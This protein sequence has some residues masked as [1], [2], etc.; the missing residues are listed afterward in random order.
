M[1]DTVAQYGQVLGA[2]IDDWHPPIMVR[3]WRALHPL[4]PGTAPMFLLQVS[5]YV[6]GFALIVAAL[7]RGGKIEGGALG[8]PPFFKCGEVVRPVRGR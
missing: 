3:L 4:A 5:L 1:Y 8:L 2:E 7:V 6:V